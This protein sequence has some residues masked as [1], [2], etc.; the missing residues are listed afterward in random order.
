M[1]SKA[2]WPLPSPNVA[3]CNHYPSPRPAVVAFLY[4]AYYLELDHVVLVCSQI[5]NGVC[6]SLGP[7]PLEE[8][9]SS[10]IVKWRLSRLFIIKYRIEFF[11]LLRIEINVTGKSTEPSTVEVALREGEYV[12]LALP[13]PFGETSFESL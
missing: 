1:W 3:Y 9:G 6:Y 13:A 8:R 2:F 12:Y 7:V 5:E 10:F 11:V 4:L